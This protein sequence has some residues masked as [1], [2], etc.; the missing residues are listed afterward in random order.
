MISMFPRQQIEDNL[1]KKDVHETN[2]NAFVS[3]GVPRSS[4]VL[5]V[6]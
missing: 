2:K 4:G 6:G 5:G 1:K 3:V